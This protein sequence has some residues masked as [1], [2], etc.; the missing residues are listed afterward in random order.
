MNRTT[1]HIHSNHD[2]AAITCR[3][4]TALIQ[5]LYLALAALLVFLLVACGE[6]RSNNQAVFVLIDIHGDYA[7]ELAKARTLTN[8]LLGSLT[9][10]DSIAIAF[11]DNSSYTKRNFIARTTFDHRPSVVNQQKRIVQSE[12]DAFLERFS[13]PSAH[14]DITGGILLARDFFRESEAGHDRLFILSDFE[15]DL[16]PGMK[17]DMSL[18]LEGAQVVAVNVIRRH[19]DNFDP[20]AYQQRLAHWR[21]RV[22][23]SEGRWELANDLERLEDMVALR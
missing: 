2:P 19:S 22:E 6:S 13:V 7:G 17:R 21:E 5:A 20:R 4:A 11:I 10:E 16:M 18:D 14:S 3:S 9:S 1:E 23:N 8:Y 15:E 12:L